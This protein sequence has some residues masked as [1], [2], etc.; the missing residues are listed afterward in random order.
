MRI[1]RLV[2]EG[3][4]PF[5][6]RQ[7]IDF[8]ALEAAGLFLITGR[9]GSGKS[10]VLDAVCFALYGGAPRYDGAK[11]RLRSDH[12]RPE[13]PTR[14]ELEFEVAGARWR[15]VRSPEYQRPK[16]RGEGFTTQREEAQVARWEDGSW[17][18]LAARA[19]D[20]PEVLAPVLQLNREQFLQVILLAQG[21][22][23][24][25]LR[26]R[27]E[28]RVGL[29]RALF[30]TQRFAA[31]EAELV[32]R[33]KGLEQAVAGADAAVAADLARLAELEGRDEPPSADAAGLVVADLETRAAAARTEGDRSRAAFAAADAEHAEQVRVA[34]LQRRRSDATAALDR[35]AAADA[36]VV[37]QR[38]RVSAALRA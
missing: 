11:A 19:A 27:S 8:A 37:A 18:T 6:R 22:F 28:D 30:G 34:G 16:R 12:A 38:A 14:V 20:L 32:Q 25:F 5:A 15:V 35:L 29:L 2:V 33:V 26:A 23:Q 7:E 24:E 10:S 36:G 3:F 13:D 21:R 17:R 1:R 9:T 4:G 31:F